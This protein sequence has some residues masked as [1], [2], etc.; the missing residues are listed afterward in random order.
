MIAAT[1]QGC[2]RQPF[3]S[4]PT[5]IF[6]THVFGLLPNPLAHGCHSKV[7][8]PVAWKLMT[9]SSA[10]VHHLVIRG[11]DRPKVIIQG[12]DCNVFLL[13]IQQN[14]KVITRRLF[15]KLPNVN[16]ARIDLEV[17]CKIRLQHN[18]SCCPAIQIGH[19]QFFFFPSRLFTAIRSLR[20]VLLGS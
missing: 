14:D 11:P 2:A 10:A 3:A 19:I 5:A 18:S 13:H 17:L 7:R 6:V 12:K 4:C 8:Q 15:F 9:W 20:A 1:K 16:S